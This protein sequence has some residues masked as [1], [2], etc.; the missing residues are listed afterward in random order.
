MIEVSVI[1]P[2]YNAEEYI[3]RCIQSVLAQSCTQFEIICVDD[4]SQDNTL[5]ILKE[6]EQKY[7]QRVKVIGRK[8]T[9][10]SAARNAGIQLATG[11]YIQ[12]L[13]ADDALGTDKIGH[14]LALLRDK[15]ECFVAGNYLRHVNG[16]IEQ[17]SVFESDKWIALAKGRLGCTCS[18]L[19]LKS[20]IVSSGGW[21]ENLASSQESELMFRLLKAGNEVIPDN[22]FLTD[23]YVRTNASISTKSPVDNLERY[24]SLRFEMY[25]WLNR[26]GELTEERKNAL[27]SIILGTLRMLFRVNDS[28]AKSIYN[29]QFAPTFEV[30]VAEQHSGVYVMIHKIFGFAI[31]QRLFRLIGK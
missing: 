4:G 6:Y 24:I 29:T 1:I 13:D 8:N 18:N 2:C 11:K 22:K 23:I 28:L 21:N 14:Q 3:G 10:A 20:D 31:A 16:K 25:D 27:G 12:F 15:E 19:F 5:S 7:P 9:G 17:V 30:R 26:N